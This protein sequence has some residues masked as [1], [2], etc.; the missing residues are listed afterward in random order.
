MSGSD[1]DTR[2]VQLEDSEES[3][4]SVEEVEDGGEIS[5]VAS[6]PHSLFELGQQ[7]D[8]ETKMVTAVLSS[9]EGRLM[10]PEE[11]TLER[12]R[13]MSLSIPSRTAGSPKTRKKPDSPL[14][15]STTS[16][17]FVFSK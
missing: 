4:E 6:A 15:L 1:G 9:P 12:R 11:E 17:N 8:D 14:L 13:S 10:Q 7:H 5:R 16:T 2:Y 3:E